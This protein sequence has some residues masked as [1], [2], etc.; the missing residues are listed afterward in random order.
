MECQEA[1]LKVQALIDNELPEQ[2]IDRVIDHVQSCYRCR[3]DYISLLKLQRKL[4]GLQYPEPPKEWFEK[5]QQKRARRFSSAFGLILFIGSYLVLLG[6]ALYSMFS[7]SDEGLFIKI[8]IA[9][10]IIGVLFLL[11]VTISDR[12]RE[13]KTDKYKEV[14][15]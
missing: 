15:K 4:K 7:D 2:E 14:M 13:S 5:L 11:G 12:V 10:I 1:K 8:V 3:E 6:Y 9:G